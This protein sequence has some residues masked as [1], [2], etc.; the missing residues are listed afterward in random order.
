MLDIKV[1]LYVYFFLFG[2]ALADLI[3]LLCNY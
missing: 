3:L 1:F 2:E